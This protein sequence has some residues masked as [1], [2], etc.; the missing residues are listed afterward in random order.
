MYVNG[1]I[2]LGRIIYSGELFILERAINL[3]CVFL[4]IGVIY[5]DGVLF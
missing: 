5:L 4:L 3:G 2:I 1:V